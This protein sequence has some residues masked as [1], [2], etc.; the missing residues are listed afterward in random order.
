MQSTR[1]A[2]L[3]GLGSIPL[4][5]LAN[6]AEAMPIVGARVYVLDG[7]SNEVGWG[8]G[9][10]TWHS[11]P[12]RDYLIK[13][14][15][16]FGTANM[17]LIDMAGEPLHFW[18]NNQADGKGRHGCAISTVRHCV[19]SHH[20]DHI[21]IIV[22]VAHNGMSVL[23]QL[24]ETDMPPDAPDWWGDACARIDAALSYPGDT[25]IDGWFSNQLESDV[26]WAASV[27][28]PHH[29]QMPDAAAFAAAKQRYID[30]VRER[31]GNGFSFIMGKACPDWTTQYGVYLKDVKEHFNTALDQVA[32][33]NAGC[34]TVDTTHLHGSADFPAHFRADSAEIFAGRAYAAWAALA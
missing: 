31:Y 15:G 22:P 29:A 11:S 23:Q 19:G 21:A 16:R 12:V 3:S 32:A 25:Y 27:D 24:G 30:R 2:I 20:P 26:I 13:Q 14:I 8:I 5:S 33:A 28:D 18:E 10:F 34:K 4:L 7:Q 17:Q 9:D 6:Q 1:R